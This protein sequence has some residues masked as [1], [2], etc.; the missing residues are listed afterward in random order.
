MCQ[1]QSEVRSAI[2]K[3]FKRDAS[4][5]YC[6]TG[7]SPT[8]PCLLKPLASLFATPPTFFLLLFILYTAPSS[9]LY[10][11]DTQI[12]IS[13]SSAFSTK[14]LVGTLS[15]SSLTVAFVV[16]CSRNWIL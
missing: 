12:C 15:A 10:T 6:F 14:L 7:S 8:G 5:M 4:A 13:F 16:G 9:H 11:D 3:S 1:F 2:M